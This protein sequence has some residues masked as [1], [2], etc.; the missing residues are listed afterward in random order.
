MRRTLTRIQRDDERGAS[1]VEF[2]L[3]VPVFV[4]LLFALIDFGLVFGGFITARAEVNAAARNIAVDELATGCSGQTAFYCTAQSTVGS[5]LPGVAGTPDVAIAFPTSSPVVG[6]PV[7][8]CAQ[9]TLES[10]TGFLGFL[11]N[12][13][14]VTV[15]S[16]VRLEQAP[17]ET[18]DDNPA[19]I[20]C[21]A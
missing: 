1:L 19:G 20:P 6:T 5:S 10:S 12:G 17:T 13:R 15:K 21:A 4:L 2:A 3:V 11:L 8:V 9:V 14:T 16:E 18:V 7:A